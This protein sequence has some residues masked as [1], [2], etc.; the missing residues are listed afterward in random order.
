M[1]LAR[2]GAALI[3]AG[4]VVGV[5]A[6]L[7]LHLLPSGL[8]PVRDPVSQYGISRYRMGYRVQTIAYA[9]AGLGAAI[10]L[11]V[12]PGS[13]ALPVVLCGVF[14]ASRAVISWFPMD[15]PG[16]P[17]TR[18][19]GQHGL[20]AA[21]TFLSVALAALALARALNRS[22]VDALSATLTEAFAAVMIAALVAMVFDRRTGGGRFGLVER[23]FYLGMTAWLVTLGVLLATVRR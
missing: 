11:A 19:G 23:A 4:L 3:A 9:V 6:L 10:G 8:S 14:A 2:V 15:A 22:H 21:A 7:A 20:L 17:S 1:E 12:L 18:A 13:T 5:A 16:G